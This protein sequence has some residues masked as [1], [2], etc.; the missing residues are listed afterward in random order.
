MQRRV[1][2]VRKGIEFAYS[3]IRGFV[4][5][6]QKSAMVEFWHL[7]DRFPKAA[8]HRLISA[9]MQHSSALIRQGYRIQGLMR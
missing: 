6:G 8:K 2:K 4:F 3:S 7:Q 9:S 5:F 1:A